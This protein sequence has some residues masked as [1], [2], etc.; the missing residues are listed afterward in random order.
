MRDFNSV[1]FSWKTTRCRSSWETVMVELTGFVEISDEDCPL[2]LPVPLDKLFGEVSVK[3]VDWGL[4]VKLTIV[5]SED[6]LAKVDCEDPLAKVDWEDPLLIVDC[7][8]PLL[9]V[10]WEDPLAKVVW[11]DPLV[12]VVWED[13]VSKVAIEDKL[14]LTELPVTWKIKYILYFLK[15]S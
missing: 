11:E 13:P 5:V 12:I 9:I 10:D 6:P 15:V 1:S 14:G 2:E 3:L 7:E 4:E 8:D